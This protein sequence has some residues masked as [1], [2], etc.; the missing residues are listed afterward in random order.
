MNSFWYHSFL[1]NILC[2]IH[3]LCRLST[4]MFMYHA[5]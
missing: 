5:L 4:W 2:C 1:L 3:H